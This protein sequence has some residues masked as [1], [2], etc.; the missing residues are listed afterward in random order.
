MVELWGLLL[1]G[2]AAV[3]TGY[4]WVMHA[5]ENAVASETAEYDDRLGRIEERLDELEAADDD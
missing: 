2:F 1:V 5:V 3:V 4:L